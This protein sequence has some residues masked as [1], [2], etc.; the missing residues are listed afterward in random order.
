MKADPKSYLEESFL[1]ELLFLPG[2]T[3]L[4]YNGEGFYYMSDREGRKKADLEVEKEEVGNFLRQIAN[5]TERS[6]SYS[7]PILDVSFDKY[8]LNAVYRSLARVR[9]EK[10]YS[11]SLRLEKEAAIHPGDAEFFPDGSEKILLSL[12]ASGD[13]IVIGGKTSTGKTE[14]EKY[15]I[16]ALPP[17]TRV[18]VIDNVEELSFASREG[19]D[20]TH[21]LV[22]PKVPEA[23]FPALIKNA[24]RNNPDYIV[25]SEARGEEMLDALISAMS[26]HPIITAVHAKSLESLPSRLARLVMMA[27][28]KLE[29]KEVLEDINEHFESYVYLAKETV[30]GRIIRYVKSIGRLDPRTGKMRLLFER[31]NKE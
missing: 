2:L 14:L 6:F 11:F 13:S 9:N 5:L 10:S 16:A 7:E 27:S 29:R 18:V 30:G 19:I 31:G 26:G 22:N 28:P 3:D 23:T 20:F 8:R 15:L 12:L 17:S 4:S 25:V 24:L 21:W 1:K